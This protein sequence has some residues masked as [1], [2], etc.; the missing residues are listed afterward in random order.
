VAI[1][2]IICS[3]MGLPWFVAATVLSI[4]HVNSL[5][6][7]EGSTA[8]G[9]APNFSGIYEQRVTGF[10]IFMLIGMSV[11]FTKV[12]LFFLK[13][14]IVLVTPFVLSSFYTIII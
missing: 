6:R 8:P 14:K 2:L 12:K 13:K 7:Y 10:L 4:T 9:E 5:K 3:I 1:A 11:L